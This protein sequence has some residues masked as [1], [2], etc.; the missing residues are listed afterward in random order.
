[1]SGANLSGANLRSFKADFWMTLT[2]S[3]SEVLGLIQALR[4]GRVDG[5]QYTGE[6]ACLVGTLA[7]LRH[8]DVSDAFPDKSSENPAEQWFLMISKGDK[9]TDDTGGG[10]ANAQAIEWALEYCA[11][12]GIEVPEGDVA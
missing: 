5:S 2:H 1:L 3:R 11:L 10:F 4:D 12:T 7:N 9:P 8:A 6:C